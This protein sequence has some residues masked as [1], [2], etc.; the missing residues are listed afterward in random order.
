MFK[1][2]QCIKTNYNIISYKGIFWNI[3]SNS[4]QSNKL[5]NL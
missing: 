3:K 5:N 1:L 4:N 2:K